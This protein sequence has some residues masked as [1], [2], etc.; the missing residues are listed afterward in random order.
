MAFLPSFWYMPFIAFTPSHRAAAVAVPAHMAVAPS[1]FTPC[2]P[3]PTVS[4][5][6]WSVSASIFA[7]RA[8]SRR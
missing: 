8:L 7:D 3:E 5:I 2:S 4:N 1:V 6:A